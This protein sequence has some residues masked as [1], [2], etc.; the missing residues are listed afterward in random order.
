VTAATPLDYAARCERYARQRGWAYDPAASSIGHLTP[1]QRRRAMRKE[2]RANRKAG[3]LPPVS[4]VID[5]YGG[6]DDYGSYD[7]PHDLGYCVTPGCRCCGGD[8][9]RYAE[10]QA[11]NTAAADLDRDWPRI[12]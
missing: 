8:D 1:K 9:E 11:E 5:S 2:D 12:P 7:D 3:W 4:L 10:L 6:L